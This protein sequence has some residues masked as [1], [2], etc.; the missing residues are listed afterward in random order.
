MAGQLA[1][2]VRV[3]PR[4]PDIYAGVAE[5]Q[6]RMVEGHVLAMEWRFKSSLPHHFKINGGVVERYTRKF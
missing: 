5:R 1:V 2:W 3:P 4:V 6:T